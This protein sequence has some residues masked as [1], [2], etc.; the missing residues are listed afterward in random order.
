MFNFFFRPYLPGFRVRPQDD[1]PGF[2]VDEN[3]AAQTQT[4]PPITSFTLGPDGLA[5]S[6]PPI[7]LAGIRLGPWDDVPRFNLNESGAPGQ[8]TTW[9][10]QMPPESATSQYP[11]AAQPLTLPRGMEHPVET[12]P[13]RLPDWLYKL[14]T[15][16]LPE[17]ST[18]VDPRTGQ[19]IVPY[20]P[21]VSPIRA[22]QMTDEN[23][24]ARA[25]LP[26]YDGGISSFPD[27][28]L[29]E[30]PRADSWPSSGIPRHPTSVLPTLSVRPSAESNFILTN[31]G[32]ARMQPAQQQTPLPQDPARQSQIPATPPGAG[33]VGR[34]LALPLSEQPRM[35]MSEL[36]R[37][38]HDDLAAFI[39]AYGRT[40]TD[41]A[42]DVGEVL[43]RFGNR[44]YEDTILRAGSD[45]RRLAERLGNDPTETITSVLN[46]F[47][48]TKVEGELVANLAA[49]F[50][51]LANVARGLAF[52]RAV[53]D[54]LNA[55]K[56]TTK[57]SVEGLGRSVPDILLRGVTEI[58]S[59]LEIDNSLQLRIQAAYAKATGVPFSLIVGPTTQ[60]VSNTVK[61]LV[62]GTG[63]TIQRFDPATGIFTP[64]Q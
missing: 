10:T 62:W 7:G 44:F 11:D 5:Q 46:S 6:A 36:E 45:L 49:V 12:T 35:E 16:P 13:P 29:F 2:N 28:R 37:R 54:A 18:A 52:E 55:A 27:M 59:G 3:D 61:G 32:D 25:S 39:E 33:P 56:N 14:V 20:A 51:I 30:A 38:H 22:Y 19:R 43:T 8:E 9:S 48:Q 15:M 53:L 24:R 4:S 60:R 31:A 26:T 47:P 57:I 41:L 21:L 34:P 64:F 17:V 42:R 40:A 23:V 63:G 58:K 50:T 1:V